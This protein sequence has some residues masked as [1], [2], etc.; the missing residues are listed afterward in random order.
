M[1]LQIISGSN[2]MGVPRGLEIL[3]LHGNICRKTC[4]FCGRRWNTEAFV[5]E[6]GKLLE[7]CPACRNWGVVREN[8][9]QF[10]KSSKDGRT[11][12]YKSKRGFY[13]KQW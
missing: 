11:R 4:K 5:T 9:F 2:N 1:A 6:T 10:H 12:A 8:D 3:D 13:K 7:E